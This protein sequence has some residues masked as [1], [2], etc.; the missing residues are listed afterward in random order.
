MYVLYVRKDSFHSSKRTVLYFFLW[1]GDILFLRGNSQL[2]RHVIKIYKLQ[3]EML[4]VYMEE[5]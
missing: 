5:N 4:N 3:M 2:C 1:G